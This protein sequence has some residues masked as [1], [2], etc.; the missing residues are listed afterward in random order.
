MTK[1]SR[2]LRIIAAMPAFNEA[3]YL[4]TM[5]LKS[6][7]YVDEVIVVDDGST[8][9][10][11]EIARL[12]GATV[13]RHEKN[14]G[15]GAAIQS[16]MAEAKKRAPDV[17]VILDSDSQHNPAEIP[18]LVKSIQDGFDMVIGSRKQQRNHIPLYRRIGQDIILRSTNILSN[19][20]LSDSESGFRAFSRKAIDSLELRENGMAV[21]AETVAEASRRGLNV[22]EVPISITYT[23]DGSTLNPLA[24]GLEVLTR[25]ITM[26]SQR[27]PL[28]F[29]G[30]GG[31]ILTSIG[32]FLGAFALKI[33]STTGVVHVGLSLAAIPL[34]TVG[35]FS[36]FTGIILYVLSSKNNKN[37]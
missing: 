5:V 2:R 4:G 25:V 27:R 11:S 28:F 19:K 36:I 32:L 16:I 20:K 24:H 31:C 3:K 1:D 22:T 6:R 29:F 23:K 13:V 14:R 35:V 18:N 9:N 21:S 33:F 37:S 26:I 15:Y 8:D 7:Q 17:L 34:L 12:A 10:T 30:L